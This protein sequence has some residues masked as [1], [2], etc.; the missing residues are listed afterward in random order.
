MLLSLSPSFSIRMQVNLALFLY[1]IFLPNEKI[2]KK[3]EA[4]TTEKKKVYLA[5]KV[6]ALIVKTYNILE[7]HSEGKFYFFFSFSSCEKSER[8]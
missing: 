2:N 7:T 1:L 6:Y 3:I 5:I 4:E 8:E